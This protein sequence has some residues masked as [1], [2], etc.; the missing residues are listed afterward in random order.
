[1]SSIITPD[2]VFTP[3]GTAGADTIGL[4]YS[5]GAAT[6]TGLADGTEVVS[7]AAGDTLTVSGLGGDD[8]ITAQNGFPAGLV[9]TLDGGSGND[10]ITGSDQNDILFGGTGNDVV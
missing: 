3:K 6:I 2:L 5:N 8:T 1:M 7:A 10:T 9:L 4:A